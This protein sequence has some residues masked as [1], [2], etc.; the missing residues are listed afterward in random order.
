M[1]YDGAVCFGV[2]ADPDAVPDLDVM[3][4]GM[5][6]GAGALLACAHAAVAVS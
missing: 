6:E 5:Q 2:A 1:S 3:L 4:A